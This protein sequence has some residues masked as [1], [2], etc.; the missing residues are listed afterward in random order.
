M[1]LI[2]PFIL[3]NLGVARCWA[4]AGTDNVPP[5]DPLTPMT[6]MVETGSLLILTLKVVGGLALVLGLMLLFFLWL[7]KMGFSQQTLHQG[8]LIQVLDTRLLGPKKYVSVLRVADECIAVGV[9]EQ[10]ITLLAR[11]ESAK[12]PGDEREKNVTE[13]PAPGFAATL[14]RAAGWKG[15]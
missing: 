14:A 11:I 6:G 12:I 3:L 8:S 13:G 9:T 4:D 7:K 5:P 10:Q 2:A 1:K 15:K